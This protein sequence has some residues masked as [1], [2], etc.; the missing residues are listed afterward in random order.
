VGPLIHLATAVP[1]AL[2]IARHA[3]PP[4]AACFIAGATLIDLDHYLFYALRTGR[5]DLPGMFNWYRKMDT[6]YHKGDYYGLHILH[7]MEFFLLIAALS[8]LYPLFAWVLLG[9]GVHFLLD[10]AWLLHLP[11]F[12]LKV[13]AFSCIEHIVRR[14]RGD[15]EFWRTRQQPNKNPQQPEKPICG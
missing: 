15:A 11:N 9:M 4:A 7:T 10:T 5:D 6:L 14:C 3:G 8:Y 1:P 13:R 2:I 12:G